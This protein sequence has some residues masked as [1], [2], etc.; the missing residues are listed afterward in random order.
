[1]A[2]AATLLVGGGL[3]MRSFHR[4][5]NVDLGF[6][7]DGLL[8]MELPLSAAKY[9]ALEQQTS[10]I[11]RVLHRVRGTPGVLAAGITTNVPMQRGTTMDSVFE[12]EGRPPANPSEVP[13]TAHR[14]VSPG[15]AE[16]LGVT[17]VKGRLLES[18]DHERAL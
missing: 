13:I 18:G 17:L 16:T 8:T 9:P 7:P 11:D 12:V 10:F 15:Y 4:L 6:R 1:M 5:Q 2:L 14:V 3:V